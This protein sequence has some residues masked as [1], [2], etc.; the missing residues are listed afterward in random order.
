[1]RR[2]FFVPVFI[3]LSYPKLSLLLLIQNLIHPLLINREH[4]DMIISFL[5]FKG[6]N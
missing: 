3:F 4:F 5:A 1:L 6:F 2:Y